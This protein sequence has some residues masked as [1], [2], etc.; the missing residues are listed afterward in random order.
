[1][2]SYHNIDINT[3]LLTS[4]PLTRRK[5]CICIMIEKEKANFKINRLKIID[6]FEADYKIIL[7]L[8]WPKIMNQ[9]AEA[10]E[11]LRKIQHEN[12]K[13]KSTTDAALITEFIIGTTK[14]N[15]EPLAIQQN[16]TSAYYDRIITKCASI[17][18]RRE[19]TSKHVYRLKANT[20]NSTQYTLGTSNAI[21]SHDKHLIHGAVQGSRSVGDEWKYIS[22][23]II[24]PVKEKAYG[25]HSLNPNGINQCRT[26]MSAF[27]DD[28][29]NFFTSHKSK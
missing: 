13:Y 25:W 9:I 2:D 17:N 16:D 3:A 4:I 14:I 15:H 12:R 6:K 11:T 7:K 18:S 22:V 24:K 29:R 19:C 28:T 20:L 10:N 1:M 5:K 8:Y 23:P 27:V 26:H 21:Y